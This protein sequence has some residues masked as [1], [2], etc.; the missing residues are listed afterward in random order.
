M[1]E[2]LIKK[3]YEVAV[4]RYAA[5]GVDVEQAMGKWQKVALT[6]QCW[7]TNEVAGVEKQGDRLSGVIQTT[8]KYTGKDRNID[9]VRAANLK[10]ARV[11]T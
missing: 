6:L 8:G 7:Q 9:E 3:A 11:I 4:Q 10:T 5:I 1:R 2:E